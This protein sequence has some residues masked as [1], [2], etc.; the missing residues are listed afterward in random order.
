MLGRFKRLVH[1]PRTSRGFE[2]TYEEQRRYAA[3]GD[4]TGGVGSCSSGGA[5]LTYSLAIPA[6]SAIRRNA[7]ISVLRNGTGT[8]T[9]IPA[10]ECATVV[11][12][13]GLHRSI[14]MNRSA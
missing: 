5:P 8:L 1:K 3:H 2:I 12:P 10:P 11:L 13:P 14:K 9:T 6:S 7:A 4:K